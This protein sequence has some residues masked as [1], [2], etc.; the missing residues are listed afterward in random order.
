MR[1]TPGRPTGGQEPEDRNLVR[2][3][4]EGARR[5]HTAGRPA[6][7]DGR[8]QTCRTDQSVVGARTK[9]PLAPLKSNI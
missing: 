8:T 5:R 2:R 7:T 6:A 9:P 4:A 1:P 3:P